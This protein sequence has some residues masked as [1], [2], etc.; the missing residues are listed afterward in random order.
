MENSHLCMGR[1][2]AP[3]P[4]PESRSLASTRVPATG[5]SSESYVAETGYSIEAISGTHLLHKIFIPGTDP[6]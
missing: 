5:Y 3:Y 2:S 4:D 1:D 6:A